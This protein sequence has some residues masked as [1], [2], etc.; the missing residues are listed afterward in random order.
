MTATRALGRADEIPAGEG[1][2][3]AVDG[4]QIAVFRLRNGDIRAVSAACPHAQGPIAD[5]QIDGA[6]VICPLHQHTFDLATGC[7]LTGQPA[8]RTYPASI[9]PAGNLVIDLG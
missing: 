8:L 3:Y 7:S 6:V 4:E 5:G 2:T 1:R 9:D